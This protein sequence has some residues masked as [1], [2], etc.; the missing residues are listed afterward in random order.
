M[1]MQR[2][3][4]IVCGAVALCSGI[5]MAAVIVEYDFSGGIGSW[6]TNRSRATP[7]PGVA[8]ATNLVVAGAYQGESD[9]LAVSARTDDGL[10]LAIPLVDDIFTTGDG[11]AGNLDYTLGGSFA[12]NISSIRMNFYGDAD[13]VG[14]LSIYFMGAGVVWYSDVSSFA[15]NWRQVAVNVGWSLDWYRLDGTPE[16]SGDYSNSLADVDEVGIT[17][18]WQQGVVEQSFGIDSFWLDDESMPVPEP[19]T[20]MMLGVALLSLGMTF[21]RKIGDSM[22]PIRDFLKKK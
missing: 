22:G 12:T 13:G 1:K 16:T 15:G 9:V 7:P 20:Y 10:P 3:W 5:A 2:V 4:A 8:Y 14:S 6:T 18:G 11:L 21:R 17:L 19:E